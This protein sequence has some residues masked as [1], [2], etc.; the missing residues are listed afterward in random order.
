LLLATAV[1][2]FTGVLL[3]APTEPEASEEVADT[4]PQATLA[5]ALPAPIG[6]PE[7]VVALEER[8][9]RAAQRAAGATNQRSIRKNPMM[10]PM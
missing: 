10:I 1:G 5:L 3:L 7:P 4:A 9:L 2:R 8:R 6:F